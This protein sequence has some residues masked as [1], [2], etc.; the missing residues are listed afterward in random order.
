MQCTKCNDYNPEN[1]EFCNRC[2]IHLNILNNSSGKSDLPELPMIN[3]VNA[4]KLGFK[5]Y[6]NFSGRSRRSEYWWFCLFTQLIAPIVGIPIIGWPIFLIAAFPQIPLATRRLHDIGESGW[7][8]LVYISVM[9][10]LQSK[11]L[12]SDVSSGGAKTYIPLLGAIA[13]TIIWIMWMVEKGNK[14][15]NKYGPDPRQSSLE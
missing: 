1:A 8:Q 15:P 2:G 13:F 3:L 12:L 7:Y 6:R 5:N 14:G 9:I 4:I 11:I 10:F